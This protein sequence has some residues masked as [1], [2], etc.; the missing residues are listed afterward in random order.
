MTK[1]GVWV[2]ALQKLAEAIGHADT[3]VVDGALGRSTAKLTFDDVD[4]ESHH[5]LFYTLAQA[6]KLMTSFDE[7]L[8]HLASLIPGALDKICEDTLEGSAV[9]AG[10]AAR[11]FYEFAER[12]LGCKTSG[13]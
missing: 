6:E 12:M 1:G 13:S 3:N 10:C 9:A 2:E 4:I 8:D 11:S 5:R 7:F